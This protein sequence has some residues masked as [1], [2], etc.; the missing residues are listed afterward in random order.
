MKQ[1]TGSII[2]YGFVGLVLSF[3]AAFA[4]MWV[5][6][7]NYG[8]RTEVEIKKIWSNNQNVLGQYT[9]KVQ[10]IASVPDMYKEDLRKVMVDVM[11]ARMGKDG[12]K[13]L[14]QFFTEQN[15][16]F[17]SSMYVKIQ[18]VIEAGRNEF[19]NAQTRL[20]DVKANYEVQLGELPRSIFL[21]LTGYP[22]IDLDVY[23]PIVA[24]D[25]HRA[26]ETGVQAP[27]KLR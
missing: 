19:Q 7:A 21:S 24:A 4:I 13:A 27:V 17:D 14:F 22:K 11:Q 8:N 15:I 20:I 12:S 16:P 18:Q 1:Q 9:L 5:Q 6:A 26:F 10:E 25:T 2:A 23:K 3:V